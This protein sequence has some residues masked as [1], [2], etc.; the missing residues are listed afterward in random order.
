MGQS[1]GGLIP[2]PAGTESLGAALAGT[3]AGCQQRPLVIYLSGHLGA[4]KT[5]LARGF[6]KALGHAGPVP[7]PTFTLVEPYDTPIGPVIH[8]DLYRISDPGELD[9]L[10]L[11]EALA[12]GPAAAVLLVEWPERG[13]TQLPDPHL[14]IRLSV[15]GSGRHAEIGAGRPPGAQLA[16]TLLSSAQL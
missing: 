15:A 14:D 12:A 10:G 2:D 5:T 16:A 4:G 6:L 11:D 9:F 13:G 7:S 1:V 3:L 8:I